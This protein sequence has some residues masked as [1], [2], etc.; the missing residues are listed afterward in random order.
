MLRKIMGLAVAAVLLLVAIAFP[1]A[2][3]GILN[4]RRRSETSA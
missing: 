3:L 2:Y 4:L 1:S